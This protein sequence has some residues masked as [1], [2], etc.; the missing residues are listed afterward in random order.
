MR[1]AEVF[2]NLIHH[3][4][5]R[6]FNSPLKEG[7]CARLECADSALEKVDELGRDVW[8]VNHVQT[9]TN[10][11]VDLLVV[12]GLELFAGLDELFDLY[13]RRLFHEGSMAGQELG[14]N[15]CVPDTYL[16]PCFWSISSF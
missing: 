13:V 2:Q 9:F 15:R 3:R 14:L 1:A 16:D 4:I 8:D 12:L 5:T 11:C 6:V 7:E 10:R